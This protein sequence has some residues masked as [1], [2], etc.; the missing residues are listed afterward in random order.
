M[1]GADWVAKRGKSSDERR[2]NEE[3]KKDTRTP[4]HIFTYA[5]ICVNS[6]VPSSLSLSLSL[7]ETYSV[8]FAPERRRILHRRAAVMQ[9]VAHHVQPR[10]LDAHGRRGDRQ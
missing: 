7:S 5:L 9:Y 6:Q 10:H 8:K 1:H 2:R 3:N 4:V